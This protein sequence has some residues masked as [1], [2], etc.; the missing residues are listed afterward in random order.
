[1]PQQYIGI[2]QQLT[3]QQ[4]IQ[5]GKQCD[6][7]HALEMQGIYDWHVQHQCGRGEFYE[8]MPGFID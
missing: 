2:Q 1:M 4:L 3:S 6:T 8:H 5:A 7:E